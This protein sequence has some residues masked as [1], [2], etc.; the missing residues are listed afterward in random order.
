VAL[1][2]TLLA[3][4]SSF[5]NATKNAIVSLKS[6]ETG[7]GKVQTSLTR[8]ADSFSGRKI[9]Q[10]ATLM[11]E[12]IDRAGGT[13]TLT[14]AELKRAGATAQEAADKFKALGREAPASLLDIAAAA[15]KAEEGTTNWGDVLNKVGSGAKTIGLGLTAALTVPILGVGAAVVKFGIDA[16][17]SEN[18][19]SVSFGSMKGKAEE[20][21]KSLSSSLGLNQ[22]ELRQTAGTIFNM[23]T[24]MGINRDAAFEMSTG[25][26][27][28]SADMSSFRNIPMEEALVKIR[29]G[30]TGEAEPLK[31]IGILV[32]D[33]TI[34]TYAYTHGLARQGEELTQQQKVMARWGAILQQ[35]SNDQGDLAR[36]LESPAN[37]LRIMKTRLEEA[38]T[39]LGVQLMPYITK[40]V[41][42]LG[43]LVPYV[44]RA[45]EWF[46]ELPE[47]VQLTAIGIAGLAAAAGPVI[48]AFGALAGSIANLIPLFT[49]LAEVSTVSK[50]SGVISLL[51]GS[52]AIALGG[53]AL[54]AGA[55]ALYVFNQR[56]TEMEDAA[57]RAGQ[58]IKNL[59]GDLV[60]TTQQAKAAADALPP[61]SEGLTFLG[62]AINAAAGKGSTS[63]GFG[64]L[65]A[66][67]K[68]A[69]K[70]IASLSSVQR[71]QLNQA[72]QAGAFDMKE[73]RQQTGLSEL[74][75]KLFK[76]QIKDAV[77]AEVTHAAALRD[78]ARAAKELEAD[79]KK[80][81]EGMAAIEELFYKQRLKISKE[82]HIEQDGLTKVTNDKIIDGFNQTKA[83]WTDYYD[84]LAKRTMTST[85]YQIQKVYEWQAAQYATFN[86]TKE[87]WA[88]FYQGVEALTA[89]KLAAVEGQHAEFVGHIKGMLVDLAGGW[90][91]HFTDVYEK[92]GS[93]KEATLGLWD[94]FKERV[95]KIL[96]EIADY[97]IDVALKKMGTA[98]SI[99][100]AGQAGIWGKLFGWI[101]KIFGNVGV[102]GGNTPP[103]SGEPAIPG[104][105]GGPGGDPV[106]GPVRNPRAL[107]GVI[108][109]LARGGMTWRSIGTDVVP[110]MLTPG[111]GIL[112]RRDMAALGG[113]SGFRAFRAGLHGAGTGGDISALLSEIAALRRDMRRDRS[114]LPK[115]IRDAVLLART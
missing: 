69:Q 102:G 114:L 51:G 53:A 77:A 10:D 46:A 57:N 63:D 43:E 82:F 111:E 23:T 101:G 97:W 26:A 79:H 15:K 68:A 100:A 86:G 4:F 30:L 104:E 65:I 91:S 36:T 7:A 92:T 2:G 38:A 42:A 108:E 54:V 11:A 3:D 48:Y 19:V 47:P 72:L 20:W 76:D 35:T 34:K 109:H 87:Q 9:I 66:Q 98:F 115:Q 40:V 93:W 75:I 113:A 89:E 33:A 58:P 60:Y 21:S 14:A 1:S 24:S 55:G 99:W 13:S 28:L 84:A 27:K 78:D 52:G 50:L 71:S 29:S 62:K 64:G 5:E 80:V 17:E 103:G 18:L 67:M 8:M 105:T 56:M 110:A 39:A 25:V 112:S 96:L 44:Q 74:A 31:A 90:V 73:L 16:V 59:N 106:G 81:A 88:L 37:Q 41:S 85:E 94:E 49:T 6:F 70:E 45:V 32:D 12:A 107:G 95:K 22:F 61:V 83:V